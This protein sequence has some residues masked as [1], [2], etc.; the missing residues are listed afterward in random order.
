MAGSKCWLC[1]HGVS[2]AGHPGDHVHWA[3]CTGFT[4]H[5]PITPSSTSD[6]AQMEALV[7][8]KGAAASEDS[9]TQWS[10]D[11]LASPV[12]T[13]ALSRLDGRPA[14]AATRQANKT[15]STRNNMLACG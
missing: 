7:R 9:K 8:D 3:M 13:V 10:G 12:L 14:A 6:P 1:L 4:P 11:K 5:S 15:H 2:W